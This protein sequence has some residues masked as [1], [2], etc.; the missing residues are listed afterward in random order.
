[1]SAAPVAILLAASASGMAAS[2]LAYLLLRMRRERV[3][4]ARTAARA[5]G[6]RTEGDGNGIRP[7]LA[8]IALRIGEAVS[9]RL[10]PR[11]VSRYADPIRRAALTE[12]LTPQAVWGWKVAGALVAFAAFVAVSQHFLLALALSTGALFLPDLWLK[13][14]GDTRQQAVLRQLPDALDLWTLMVE[15]GLSFDQSV[16]RSLERMKTGPLSGEM[17]RF[18]AEVRMGSS[19]KDALLAAAERVGLPE[20]SSFATSVAEA[21]RLGATMGPALRAQADQ[22]RLRRT[23]RAEKRAQEAPIRLLFPLIAFVMPTVFIVLFG[24]I[25]LALM[26][27]F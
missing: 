20:F 15:A 19:R 26:K 18:L 17:R 1:M 7:R 13:E 27:T 24:P 23:Q 10:P 12:S 11:W 25:V 21:Q 8:G 14:Q 16:L 6:D 5:A 22:M 9:P 4:S 3:L 2:L